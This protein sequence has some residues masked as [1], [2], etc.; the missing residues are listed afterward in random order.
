MRKLDFFGGNEK[1]RNI[2]ISIILL[3]VIL[4][5]VNFLYFRDMDLVFALLN[6][7]TAFLILGPTLIIKY[8][9]YKRKKEIESRFPD[10][11]RDVSEA[12]GA[13]MNLPKAIAS[14]K[15][16]NYGPLT[17][18]VKKIANQIDWGI[19]FEKVLMNFADRVGSGLLKRTASTIIEAHDSGGNIKDTLENVS[20][21]SMEIERLRRERSS[22]IYSQMVTGYVIF[23][24]FL[25]VMIGLQVFLIPSLNF[26]QQANV[27]GMELGTGFSQG[28]EGTQ[29]LYSN[30]FQWLIVIQG[31]FS[32]VAI[33]KM[34][35]G[36]IMSG[37]RH[38]VVL[39]SLGYSL[40]LIASSLFGGVSLGI[41][42]S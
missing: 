19:K 24:I 8:G 11:L 21:T 12:V 6:I 27:Q 17:P 38:S 31:A 34:A 7:L 35:E 30:M 26:Q 41:L 37:L 20:E 13:G 15:D 4:L 33:G 14:T 36:T 16:N 40:F 28:G 18:Y 22:Q 2:I 29:E 42:P 9:E 25:G 10:F 23:F 39:V 32:G 3:A 5:V 1:E